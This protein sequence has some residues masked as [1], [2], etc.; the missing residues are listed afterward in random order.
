MQKEGKRLHYQEMFENG[1]W[2][3]D[4]NQGDQLPDGRVQW[5]CEGKHR[6]EEFQWTGSTHMAENRVEWHEQCELQWY[7]QD[8]GLYCRVE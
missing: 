8:E 5:D 4:S 2:N 3:A 7:C 6:N 1:L